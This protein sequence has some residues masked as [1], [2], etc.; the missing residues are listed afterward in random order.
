[1]EQAVREKERLYKRNLADTTA[2][3]ISEKQILKSKANLRALF[4]HTD[5]AYILVNDALKVVSYNRPAEKLREKFGN[6]Q[7]SVGGD[8]MDYF[9][10]NRK[11]E[12]APILPFHLY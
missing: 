2:L 8:A 9:P 6:S 7:L 10:V 1:M 3:K 11:S 12:I 5:T 4:D